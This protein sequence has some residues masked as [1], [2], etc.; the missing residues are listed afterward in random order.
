[1]VALFPILLH[2]S[3]VSSLV[4]ALQVCYFPSICTR[5]SHSTIYA[6]QKNSLTRYYVIRP[7]IQT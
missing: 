1:M 6:C 7:K 5:Q 3:H 4:P 2:C